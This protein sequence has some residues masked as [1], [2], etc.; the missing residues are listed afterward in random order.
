MGIPCADLPALSI[1]VIAT[2]WSAEDWCDMFMGF[3]E[4]THVL[5]YNTL[6]E[7]LL[8]AL[9]L[10]TGSGTDDDN[11]NSSSSEG[12]GMPPF[13]ELISLTVGN[14][15]CGWMTASIHRESQS[16]KIR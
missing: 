2:L 4:I 5:A 1:Q 14:M 7:S 3:Q 10:T 9:R 8:N 15:T 11:T 6:A 13:Q 12:N 16:C